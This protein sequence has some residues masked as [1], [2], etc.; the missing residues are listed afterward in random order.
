MPTDRGYTNLTMNR[1]RTEKLRADFDKTDIEQTFNTWVLDISESA[2]AR[3]KFIKKQ[4][5]QYSF[6]DLTNDGFAIYDKDADK[7]ARIH[8]D[9]KNLICS[10]HQK[11][12]CEHKLFAGLHPLFRC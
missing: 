2:L 7:I 1:D 5:P 10:D 3:Y 6:V 11:K 4:L 9:G 8:Y 12:V